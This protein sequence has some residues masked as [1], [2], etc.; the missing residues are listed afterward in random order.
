M[1]TLREFAQEHRFS[2]RTAWNYFKAGKIA[3][4]RKNKFGKILIK[5]STG[6]QK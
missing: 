5:E 4:A 3:A 1:K 6:K 2:Y